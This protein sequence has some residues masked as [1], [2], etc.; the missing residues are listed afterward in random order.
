MV[1]H[2]VFLASAAVFSIGASDFALDP[3]FGDLTCDSEPS[4]APPCRGRSV[5][6]VP[7]AIYGCEASWDAMPA[8]DLTKLLWEHVAF[9][10]ALG[11]RVC[12]NGFHICDNED[13]AQFLGLSQE[14]CAQ[15]P[16]PGELFLSAQ[17]A[18]VSSSGSASLVL[19]GCGRDAKSVASVWEDGESGLGARLFGEGLLPVAQNDEAGGVP[20][21]WAAAKEWD[22]SAWHLASVQKRPGPGGVLCCRLPRWSLFRT[23]LV[24]YLSVSDLPIRVGSMPGLY[25]KIEFYES[26]SAANAGMFDPAALRGPGACV[27]GLLAWKLLLQLSLCERAAADPGAASAAAAQLRSSGLADWT[28]RLLSWARILASGWPVFALLARLRR[29]AGAALDEAVRGEHCPNGVAAGVE[30][31]FRRAPIEDAE[32]RCCCSTTAAMDSELAFPTPFL[33]LYQNTLVSTIDEAMPASLSETAGYLLLH[34]PGHTPQLDSAGSDADLQLIFGLVWHD[35]CQSPRFRN[36][37][38]SIVYS[39]LVLLDA[40]RGRQLDAGKI[41]PGEDTMA[42]V[43]DRAQGCFDAFPASDR[44]SSLEELVLCGTGCWPLAAALD[45]LAQV[46]ALCVALRHGSTPRCKEPWSMLGVEATV[47]QQN[48]EQQHDDMTQLPPPPGGVWVQLAAGR[49]ITSDSLRAHRSLERNCPP[50]LVELVE[51]WAAAA[52]AAVAAN[53]QPPPQT[54]VVEVGPSFVSSCM[55]RARASLGSAGLRAL[56]VEANPKSAGLLE[57]TASM[58]GW[59]DGSISVMNRAASDTVGQRV[60]FSPEGGSALSSLDDHWVQRSKNTSVVVEAER[61]DVLVEGW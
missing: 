57:A 25:D 39:L 11:R 42:A 31:C 46:P 5:E 61:L 51:A 52:A 28:L 4:A 17:V 23:R 18:T 20:Q 21:V 10:V 22:G 55:I 15:L 33:C 43:L 6:L 3:V 35:V 56:L 27:L 36:S 9:K 7:Q 14:S 47:Q 8:V 60:L 34:V 44:A 19:L 26:S 54:T 59:S 32:L 45:R 16:A 49:D 13:E 2:V 29:C 50:F 1:L 24:Q 41:F 58:N 53:S 40:A 48:H 30:A 12:G 37:A 38:L